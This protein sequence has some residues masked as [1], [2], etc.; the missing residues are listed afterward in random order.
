MALGS[1]W[2][3]V[4]P[5]LQ[6]SENVV[7]WK[8]LDIRMVGRAEVSA[9]NER[10][11]NRPGYDLTIKGLEFRCGGKGVPEA[12]FERY[13]SLPEIKRIKVIDLGDKQLRYTPIL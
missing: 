5:G 3:V 12:D 10:R 7:Y 2:Q 4:F 11:V 9:F 6:L 8:H 1:S 13:L